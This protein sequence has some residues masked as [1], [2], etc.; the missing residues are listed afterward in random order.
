VKA[1]AVSQ[2]RN[3]LSD[4]LIRLNGVKAQD[5]GSHILRMVV[6]WD[7]DKQREIVLLTNHL[8]FGATTIS[9]I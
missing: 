4:Q 2:K 8:E 9:D 3:I 6:V 1:Q 7:E 5:D